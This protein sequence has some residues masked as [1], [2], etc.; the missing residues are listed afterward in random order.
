M[1]SAP[2][3]D[4]AVPLR[5]SFLLHHSEQLRV[6]I[7]GCVLAQPLQLFIHRCDLDQARHVT[8]GSDWNSHMRHFE[9]EDLVK[10]AVE[11]DPI[12]LIYLLPVLPC[13]NK[14]ETLFDS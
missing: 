1:P 10:F 2:F 5:R 9:A 7:H 4:T 6:E 14:V 3:F 13:D 12:D 8:A 11:S